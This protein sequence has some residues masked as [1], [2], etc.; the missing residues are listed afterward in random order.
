MSSPAAPGKS[1]DWPSSPDESTTLMRGRA[2]PPPVDYVHREPIIE[3]PEDAVEITA[4][5]TVTDGA[6]AV[7]PDGTVIDT[8]VEGTVI[9]TSDGVEL[10]LG[11]D[12][13][14]SVDADFTNGEVA[15]RS[16]LAMGASLQSASG[17]IVTRRESGAVTVE[18]PNGQTLTLNTDGTVDVTLP[19]SYDSI[20]QDPE[21]EA[22]VVAAGVED[23]DG[24]VQNPVDTD[25]D[26]IPDYRDLDS[27]GD[28]IP[29]AVEA[30]ADE[31]TAEPGTQTEP[32]APGGGG[33]PSGGGTPSGGG[34]TPSGGGDTGGGGDPGGGGGDDGGG[35]PTP[36][37]TKDDED[38]GDPVETE[39]QVSG[40]DFTV[41]ISD[42]RDDAAH[43]DDLVG[44][45]KTLAACWQAAG[46]LVQHWGLWSFGAPAY[47]KGTGKFAT[48][49]E[50]AAVEMA[51]IADG[52]R[53][54]ADQYEE[55][56]AAGVAISGTINQ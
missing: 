11:A 31:V 36:T 17:T 13:I 41:D 16:T 12:G 46:P 9:T 33:L 45:A 27:D 7:I 19:S 38:T 24:L 32:T 55:Q 20:G 21:G 37:R 2:A 52:L 22:G 3:V 35:T 5:S 49:Y 28:G 44:P 25:G 48:L 15:D 14:L 40:K 23:A 51:S 53:R 34:G 54:S 50:G 18:Q 43:F 1:F 47:R 56:E 26:G 4:S 30:R 29:D 39:P 10:T 6:V 42:M 8:A